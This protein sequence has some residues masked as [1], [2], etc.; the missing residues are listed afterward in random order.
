[1]E[2]DE[3]DCQNKC[4][5]ARPYFG[6]SGHGVKIGPRCKESFS[7]FVDEAVEM[8]QHHVVLRASQLIDMFSDAV[9]NA[10]KDCDINRIDTN[11]LRGVQV[12]LGV[13]EHRMIMHIVKSE[14]GHRNES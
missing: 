10:W 9:D 11:R 7:P 2:D 5:I 3:R 8:A 6:S 4:E 12:L 14:C 13:L 1:M